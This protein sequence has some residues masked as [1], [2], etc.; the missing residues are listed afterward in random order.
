[1]VVVGSCPDP[2][3]GGDLLI[4]APPAGPCH[5]TTVGKQ[6][7]PSQVSTWRRSDPR[8][9]FLSLDSLLTATSRELL[10][11]SQ[12]AILVDSAIG[13]LLVDASHGGRQITL[14]GFKPEDSNWPLQSSFPL[15]AK[16]LI[17]LSRQH[18]AVLQR[19]SASTGSAPRIRV[20]LQVTVASLKSP[21][22]AVTQLPARDG[23]VQ[24]PQLL[25]AGLYHLSWQGTH[26]GSTLLAANLASASEAD[27]RPV[28]EPAP[29]GPVG[30][31]LTS[32]PIRRLDSWL[33][34]VGLGLVAVELLLW[35][36]HGLL[37]Q[38]RPS[39]EPAQ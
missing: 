4:V 21:D 16:N 8:L 22:G 35:S 9:R 18:R 15:F 17:D 7:G 19:A 31:G 20:P 28:L 6:L 39:R 27:L 14:M 12:E 38:R 30:M 11:L 24:L 37:R 26:A 29:S 32:N 25:Q 36:R 10:A 34:L 3:A 5:L 23:T 1:V 13:S 2:V 33:A